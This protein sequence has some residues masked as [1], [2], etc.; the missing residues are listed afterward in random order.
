MKNSEQVAHRRVIRRHH[1]SSHFAYMIETGQAHFGTTT[2]SPTNSAETISP[3][4]DPQQG[5][6]T[7]QDDA[8]HT[9]S[10]RTMRRCMLWE[11][12][13]SQRTDEKIHYLVRTDAESRRVFYDSERHVGHPR[14]TCVSVTISTLIFSRR[15][16][17][18]SFD[19]VFDASSS[20]YE[21]SR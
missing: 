6:T 2:A 11:S 8:I 4:K 19:R 21:S 12:C 17:R 16:P 13:S 20:Q 14:V 10:R 7:A 3:T 15:S 9:T 18:Q 1:T 5:S